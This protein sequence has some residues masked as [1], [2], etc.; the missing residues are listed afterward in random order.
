VIAVLVRDEDSIDLDRVHSALREP[1]Q[2]LSRAQSPIDQEPCFL[3][4]DQR[5]VSRTPAAEDGEV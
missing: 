3:R 1:Q 4:L 5:G 2:R